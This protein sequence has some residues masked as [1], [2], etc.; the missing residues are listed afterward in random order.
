VG[1]TPL[2]APCY[3]AFARRH[4]AFSYA[5]F[6]DRQR[7]KQKKKLMPQ[8]PLKLNIYQMVTDLIIASLAK[9]VIPL[10]VSEIQ[11]RS[12]SSESRDL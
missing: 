9:G 11:R 12:L 2:L 1:D 6:H 4:S 10:E 8:Q 3:P 7:Q 5:V